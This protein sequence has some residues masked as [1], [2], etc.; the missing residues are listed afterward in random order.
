MERCE[1][2][3]AS[4]RREAVH[5]WL[6]SLCLRLASPRSLLSSYFIPPTNLHASLS[7]PNGLSRTD[8]MQAYTCKRL[9]YVSPRTARTWTADQ[10]CP[11]AL[12]ECCRPSQHSTQLISQRASTC[13]HHR[14]Y[15]LSVVSD[16]RANQRPAFTTPH[17]RPQQH[18]RASQLQAILTALSL[19]PTG[20]TLTTRLQCPV[21]ARRTAYF[22]RRRGTQPNRRS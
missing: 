9:E 3:R 2:C 12:T 11:T 1:R 18:S 22:K 21:S 15:Y 6:S 4:E 10:H 5:N 13:P 14:P 19:A 17:Q 8:C 16:T 20:D 7:S